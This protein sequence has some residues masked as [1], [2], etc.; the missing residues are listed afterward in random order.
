MTLWRGIHRGQT[1][2]PLIRS[3]TNEPFGLDV[4]FNGDNPIAD[5]VAVHGLNGHREGT[6]TAEASQAN[7]LRDL[8]P[9]DIPNA[10]ILSYGYNSRTH[11]AENLSLQSI[12]EHAITLVQDLCTYRRNTKTENRPIIFLAH[13]LGGILVK[14]ALIHSKLS[15]SSHHSIKRCTSGVAFFGTPHVGT[16]AANF[17]S[18]VLSIGSIFTRTNSTVVR[19]LRE[20]SESLHTQLQQFNPISCDFQI[21]VFYETYKTNIKFGKRIVIVP[22]HSASLPGNQGGLCI[23][24]RKSHTELVRFSC[25][26]DPDYLVVSDQLKILVSDASRVLETNSVMSTATSLT[27]MSGSLTSLTVDCKQP[28]MKLP[29]SLPLQPNYFVGRTAELNTLHDSLFG[30]PKTKGSSEEQSR[31][32]VVHG[33]GGAGKT[34]LS[35]AYAQSHRHDVDAVLWLDGSSENNTLLSFRSIAQRFLDAARQANGG[36][37]SINPLSSRLPIGEYL[38]ATG[39]ISTD[40]KTLPKISK[41]VMDFLRSENESFT[42]LMIMDNVDDLPRYPVASFLPQSARGKIIITTRRTEAIQFGQPL[43]IGQ[44]EEE[45]GIQILLNASSLRTKAPTDPEN[46][47]TIAISLGLLPL[48]LEQAGAYISRTQMQLGKYPHLLERHRRE[49]LSSPNTLGY[50]QVSVFATWELSF[51]QLVEEDNVAG[52]L[53]TLLAFFHHSSFWE[54]LLLAPFESNESSETSEPTVGSPEGYKWLHELSSSEFKLTNTLGKIFSVSLAKRNAPSGNIHLHPLV[55]AW[56]RE[57]LTPVSRKGKLVEAVV[58]IGSALEWAYRPNRTSSKEVREF[59]SRVVPNADHCI[60][61]VTQEGSKEMFSTILSDRQSAKALFYIGVLF[62][63]V[64]KLRQAEDIFAAIVAA[65]EN[66]PSILSPL[67]AVNAQR[68]LAHVVNLFSRYKEGETLLLQAIPT[69]ISLVGKAHPDT[70]AAQLELG[71]VHHRCFRYAEAEGLLREVIENDTDASTGGKMGRMGREA[72]SILGLVYKH[73]GLHQEAL[74]LL[75]RVLDQASEENQDG[76]AHLLTLKYRHTL[77]LQELGHW[78]LA[79]QAYEEAFDGFKATLGFNHPLTL[80]TANALGRIYCFLGK[81]AESRDILDL[82]WKGQSALGFSKENETA[83]LRTLFNIGVLNREEGRPN[84][85][86]E[87][88]D[89]ALRAEQALY[90]ARAHSTLRCQ[91]ELGILQ[92]VRG[93]LE[94]AAR[95][96]EEALSNQLAHY[97]DSP[98]EHAHT[99]TAL[100]EAFTQLKSPS[101]ADETLEPALRF[102]RA[103]LEPDN[104]VRLKVELAHATSL[105]AGGRG[106]EAFAETK[107]L[108]PLLESTFGLKHPISV[109]GRVLFKDSREKINDIEGDGVV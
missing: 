38:S 14:N 22:L 46:A 103:T 59:V 7:W 76:A 74:A 4:I 85:A 97:P 20:N 2:P 63:N 15:K 105:L 98:M 83:Q 106:G 60:G 67:M 71:N 102:V 52:N 49:L 40:E 77:I 84:E 12:Y 78:N 66:D 41:I 72:T 9:A 27:A 29:F 68:R 26:A 28:V 17:A 10:R 80:R 23:P 39:Q 64:S 43:E 35:V 62:E 69:L 79:M 104:P 16:S 45:S 94:E 19:Q 86:F 58:A 5:I 13:S 24:L 30:T 88:L 101:Q 44:I 56:G 81:Y 99:R 65:Y 47:K 91:V 95:N 25:P 37:E 42:W 31:V 34:Q 87:M 73:K 55:H 33:L 109:R 96:L 6:W 100:A 75:K 108:V 82:V 11:N 48:A 51:K 57:R 21:V 1:A 107:K 18:I 8:L 54:G 50:N 92:T 32:V 3:S 89:R 90:G 93:D 61:L 53:L 36:E 70:L